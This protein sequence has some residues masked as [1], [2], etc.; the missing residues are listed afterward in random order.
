MTKFEIRLITIGL[1]SIEEG[2][3]MVDVGAGTGSISVEAALQGA[4]VYAIEKEIEGIYLINENSKKFNV[5]IDIIQSL[6]PNG[7][8]DVPQFNK[9]FIGGSGGN[10]EE[11]FDSVDNKLTSGGILVANFITLDN[12]NTFKNC[13]NKSGYKD[14]EIRL[15]QSSTA[16]GKSGMLKAN[17]PIFIIKGEKE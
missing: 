17:N 2:D 1:L 11:I 4:K 9:C 15:I 16:I 3:V 13:M 6:A 7:L 8:D 10:L 14:I 12:L 5:N